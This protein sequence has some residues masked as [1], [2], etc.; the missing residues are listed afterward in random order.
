MIYL[1]LKTTSARIHFSFI[2]YLLSIYYEQVVGIRNKD[3][4]ERRIPHRGAYVLVWRK[5]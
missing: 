4:Q 2:K 5:N 1:I 3:E